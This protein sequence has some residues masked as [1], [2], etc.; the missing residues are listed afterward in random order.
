MLRGTG[1][2]HEPAE[3]DLLVL[4][5]QVLALEPLHADLIRVR[6]GAARELAERGAAAVLVGAGGRDVRF[7]EAA[8]AR[9]AGVVELARIVERAGVAGDVDH[10]HEVRA[11]RDA[12]VVVGAALHQRVAQRRADRQHVAERHAGLVGA[13]GRVA[14][15]AAAHGDAVAG[16]LIVELPAHCPRDAVV[17]SGQA[18]AGRLARLADLAVADRHAPGRV[19]DDAA[20]VGPRRALLAVRAVLREGVALERARA[21]VRRAP[22]VEGT[23]LVAGVVDG[24]AVAAVGRRRRG[25]VGVGRARGGRR[26][27]RRARRARTTRTTRSGRAAHARA[28]AVAA[29][30]L[31]RLLGAGRE[32]HPEQH[33]DGQPGRAAALFGATERTARLG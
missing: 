32:H 21:D 25:A 29:A 1:S 31:E 19:L 13:A 24:V 8:E 27:G 14:L 12:H 7:G 26:G 3:P 20:L 22:G 4:G 9:V 10:A 18:A 23:A 33:A 28:G 5:L 15:R 6:A 2:L 16:A 30:G 17:L 11:L